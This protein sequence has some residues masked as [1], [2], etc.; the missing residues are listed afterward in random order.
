MRN[1]FSKPLVAAALLACFPTFGA[2]ASAPEVSATAAAAE[3]SAQRRA[4]LDALRP[5]V[6]EAMRGPVEFVVEQMEVKDGWALVL[7]QPQRPGGGRIDPR[8]VLPADQLEFTDG[9]RIDA[10]LRFKGG[11]WMPEDFKVGATDVWY[12]CYPGAPEAL[13][14]C[15]D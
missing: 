10:L 2:A 12:V 7:A 11:K 6:V 14:G 5:G 15:G 8:T 9:L 3:G 1:T 13:T 4:I